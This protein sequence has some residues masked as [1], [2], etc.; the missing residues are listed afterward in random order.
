MVH[1]KKVEFLSKKVEYFIRQSGV[2]NQKSGVQV[3]YM[4]KKVEFFHFKG[5]LIT[6]SKFYLCIRLENDVMIDDGL[7]FGSQMHWATG[8]VVTVELFFII[9]QVFK[10]LEKPEDKRR[11]RY[12]L[13]LL[14]LL[15]HNMIGGLFP[16][17]NMK[18]PIA[19][20]RL[21][22]YVGRLA[23]LTYCPFYF[24]KSF[25]L[26]ALKFHAR[27][28]IWLF[29]IGPFV[30]LFCYALTD[31]MNLAITCGMA[32]S[33]SYSFVSVFAIG[34]AIYK[35]YKNQLFGN[36]KEVVLL[37][38]AI[39][40]CGLMVMMPTTGG[41][42]Q[43]EKLIIVNTV[44]LIFCVF[45]VKKE[46]WGIRTQESDIQLME[47]IIAEQDAKILYLEGLRNTETAR[48]IES[49]EPDDSCIEAVKRDMSSD[50]LDENCTEFLTNAE[51]VKMNNQGLIY[52]ES[53]DMRE[54]KEDSS[55]KL[56]G[57]IITE[58]NAKILYLE[59][60]RN[61]DKIRGREPIDSNDSSSN[62]DLD[63]DFFDENCA[64]Y[65]TSIQTEV[66]KMAY[67][68]LTYKKIAEIR[69]VEEDSVKKLMG[70]V[71]RRLKVKGKGDV[72]LKLKSKITKL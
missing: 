59:G 57:D 27:W 25:T 72:L 38:I 56:L 34:R 36:S 46:F 49:I 48:G 32:V 52:K 58:Q 55:K 23:I 18:I 20:Q 1:Q 8:F 10:C 37:F 61:T 22:C 2:R 19:G 71:R 65:L 40:P 69:G 44:F 6:Q 70:S 31:N 29:L 45:Y 35:K 16:D 53:A 4:I 11:Q 14:L 28:G 12:L 50:D 26:S 43:L 67:Q 68:G 39:V 3:E 30:F 62:E 5:V 47:G 60:L 42:S 17:Q 54:V 51:V 33:I 66:A 64:K 24:Y 63:E 13:L 7:L 41:I 9:Y 21:L 15:V